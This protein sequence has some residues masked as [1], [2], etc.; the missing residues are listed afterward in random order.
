MILNEQQTAVIQ[1]YLIK[2][3]ITYDDIAPEIYDHICSQVEDLMSKGA[4]FNVAFSLIRQK[5]QFVFSYDSSFWIGALWSKPRI[6]LRKS[7][8]IIKKIYSQGLILG[9]SICSILYFLINAEIFAPQQL[10]T[11]VYAANFIIFIITVYT[12]GML[13]KSGYKSIYSFIFISKFNPWVSL[14]FL[15]ILNIVDTPTT[16]NNYL[17]LI[18]FVFH[19]IITLFF[20]SL[21]LKH[22][23]I[24]KLVKV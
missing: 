2:S 6:V 9:A 8:K 11:A 16:M 20:I 7:E 3:G 18:G 4:S 19:N 15:Y 10:F 5:W 22:F 21:T 1:N 13:L 14:I 24:K 17:W 23:E 12:W